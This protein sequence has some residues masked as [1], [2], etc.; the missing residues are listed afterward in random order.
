MIPQLTL[1]TGVWFLGRDGARRKMRY[2]KVS[3]PTL[4]MFREHSPTDAD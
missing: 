3:S 4:S 2:E 1:A